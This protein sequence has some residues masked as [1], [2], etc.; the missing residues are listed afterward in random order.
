MKN[1]YNQQLVKLRKEKGLSIKEAAKQIGIAS[2]RLFLYENGYFRPKGK[3]QE[4]I[5]NFYGSKIDFSDGKEY[6]GPFPLEGK[7]KKVNKKRRIITTSIICGVSVALFITGFSLFTSSAENKTSYYGATY[8]EVRQKTIEIGKV[9]HDIVT[10]LE[11][12]YIDYDAVSCVNTIS[13]YK[14]NNILYFNNCTYSSTTITIQTHPELGLG[15]FHYQF[16]GHLGKNSFVCTF[17]YGSSKAGLFFTCDAIYQNKQL[18]HVNNIVINSPGNVVKLDNALATSLFNLKIDEAVKN[19][20][21]LLTNTMGKDIS[22]YKDF[23]PAREKGR[24]VNFALQITG[25]VM[26]FPSIIAF[27]VSVFILLIAVISELKTFLTTFEED[28]KD[29]ENSK[30]LPMDIDLT[31]GIPDYIVTWISKILFYGSMVMLAFCTV[32]GLLF[33]LPDFLTSDEF[34][35]I[36]QICFVASPFLDQVVSYG[37]IK[38][39]RALFVEIIKYLVLYLAVATFG[40]SL[41]GIANIWGYEIENILYD[42]IP[43]NFFLSIVFNYLVFLFLFFKPS[44]L[45]GKPYWTNVVWKA[46]SVIPLSGL[47]AMAIVGNS[48]NLFYGVKKNVYLLLWFSNTNII[49]SL[50]SV[51]FVYGLF[52]IKLIIHKKYGKKNANIYYNGNRFNLIINIMG[53]AIVLVLGFID[54]LFKYNQYAYYMGIGQNIYVL[55]LIPFFLLCKY[56]PNSMELDHIEVDVA[57][58]IVE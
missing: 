8:T 55:T 9:N 37:S 7:K 53:V 2:F 16:G 19:F 13:F 56:G 45:K 26:V 39:E 21:I 43:S 33:K 25:L 51:F 48:Y 44:F 57:R 27:F 23:L 4:A 54:Y 17:T 31:F 29:S 10:D 42:Y 30:P 28:E 50:I 40:T 58:D 20:D 12:Y 34:K 3:I 32:G 18:T 35:K 11:Y 22:F 36:L 47:I 41:F 14:T 24:V 49:Y 38:K 6:P 1:A 46:L 52:V 15:R 5:E